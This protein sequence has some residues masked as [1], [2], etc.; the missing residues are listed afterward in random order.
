VPR[1]KTIDKKPNC[2][3]IKPYFIALNADLFIDTPL[4]IR[5]DEN[6]WKI[7]GHFGL[8]AEH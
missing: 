5:L 8:I 6:L 1:R 2:P 4:F 3:L 7:S